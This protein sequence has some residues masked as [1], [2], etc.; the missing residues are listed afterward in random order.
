M[1]HEA[2][3]TLVILL[4]LFALLIK[5]KLPPAAVFMGALTLAIT[6]DLAPTAELLHGFSNTGMLTIGVLF[7]VASG[8]YST[9]AIS[10]IS[11]KLIGLPKTVFKAQLK[12][13]PPV[14]LGSAFLNN[15]PIVAMMIPIIRDI[16]RAAG[17]SGKRLYIPL[18]FASILGGACTLIGTATNLML[19]GMVTDELAKN[20]P[21]LPAMRAIQ[22]FDPAFVAVPVLVAGLIF[23]MAL[24]KWL[25]P[26]E[27]SFEE[28]LI[29]TRRHYEAEFLVEEG[30]HMVGKS[31]KE[32]GFKH[33]TECDLMMVSTEDDKPVPLDFDYVLKGGEQLTFSCDI[34]H[35]PDL[36]SMIGL[37]PSNT[38]NKLESERYTH[39]LVEAVISPRSAVIG[40]K[41]SDLPL[42]GSPY[43]FW[44]VALSR[45]GRPVAEHISDT[46][47]KANDDVVMEVE[48]KFFHEPLNEKEF[49]LTRR[50][51]G[52]HLP[53]TNRALMA[54][55]ITIT[56]I[57]MVTLGFMSM[58]N[59][60]LLASGAMLL[61][62]CMTLKE[63]ANSISYSTL[64]VMACAIGLESAVSHTGLARAIADGLAQVG[65]TN[66][67]VALTAIFIGAVFMS[68]FI[69]HAAA[70]ALMFPI[71]LNTA[72]DLNISFMPF[73]IV[74]MLGAS[75]SFIS[76]TGYQTN[77][78]VYGPGGYR[79]T[80]FFR[81]GI[82]LTLLVTLVT[83][84][85]TPLFFSF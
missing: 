40:R 24:N 2:Y 48:N 10:M 21:A 55:A 66:P 18:S 38:V 54:A 65:G 13:L 49:L 60:A 53:R 39:H 76:P 6:L 61:T 64:V 34:D 36:W 83:V 30:G 47:L 27:L 15:T 25:L 56:M 5:T 82:P 41:V 14:A 67:Y 69:A 37:I 77:L 57:G 84:L 43:K 62:G 32:A 78:M 7:I 71:A 4:G 51:R 73:A 23:M 31:L 12:M 68:N 79:F 19:A 72:V 46:R 85:L 20:D 44:L 81:I 3:L 74:I 58:L 35:L 50:L 9:G 52:A 45:D 16:S 59:A 33:S 42:P 17:L 8:M 70:V 28:H 22:M 63:A 75:Y 11:D 1:S 29:H 26:K 80:D